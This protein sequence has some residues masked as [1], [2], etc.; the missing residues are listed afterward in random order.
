M[1][2]DPAILAI[3]AVD[4]R[5]VA[6]TSGVRAEWAA[7]GVEAPGDGR[8]FRA[9]FRRPD[10]TFRR[11]DRASRA[12]VL[13]AEAAGLGALLPRDARDETALVIETERG[14][15][16]ADLRFA[17]SLSPGP[18]I[19]AVFPFTLPSASLGE[20]AIRHH[21]RGPAICLSIDA[22]SAGAALEEAARLLEDGEARFAVAGC[23][24]V[25]GP[26]AGLRGEL[27]A[28]IALVAAAETASALRPWPRGPGAFAEL[29]A[30]AAAAVPTGE[31]AP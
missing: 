21:L 17:R 18:P 20:V 12:L 2:R 19:G 5:G 9:L 27:R 1:R 31:S 26:R 14:S 30:F 8:A 15:L 10:P 13:A 16:E 29:A 22:G 3:G 24:E 25:C 28:V 11:L 4:A 6:G 7:L 23:V